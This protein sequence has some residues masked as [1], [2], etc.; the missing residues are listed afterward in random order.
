MTPEQMDPA[1]IF[2]VIGDC[3]SA[4]MILGLAAVL[5]HAQPGE[6]ILAVSYGSGVSD[7]LSLIVSQQIDAKETTR[8]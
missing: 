8:T 3:G 6:R 1:S 5:D 2:P 7:A 4:S